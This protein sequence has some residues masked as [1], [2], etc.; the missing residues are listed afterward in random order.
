MDFVCGISS[1]TAAC[2]C[3]D[4]TEL[5]LPMQRTTVSSGPLL[6]QC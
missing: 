4:V 1:R 2:N 6:I 5:I 3:E